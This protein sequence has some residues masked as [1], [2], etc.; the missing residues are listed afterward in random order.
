VRI[1]FKNEEL[2][3]AAANVLERYGYRA[4]RIGNVVVSNCPILLAIPAIERSVG[5]H[6]VDD[7][8]LGGDLEGAGNSHGKRSAVA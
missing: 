5:V 7:L 4:G 2:A 8:E 3:C 1:S 6:R